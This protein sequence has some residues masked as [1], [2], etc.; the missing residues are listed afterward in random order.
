M[1]PVY[2]TIQIPQSNFTESNNS[3]K[4]C[5]TIVLTK[6]IPTINPLSFDFGIHF[7]KQQK[8][9]TSQHA[10]LMD[11]IITIT[12]EQITATISYAKVGCL[13]Q[14]LT[15]F[16]IN[17]P[18]QLSESKQATD[19]SKIAAFINVV[20]LFY[21]YFMLITVKETKTVKEF[22]QLQCLVSMQ[23]C[24]IQIVFSK[25]QYVNNQHIKNITV[26]FVSIYPLIFRQ[27]GCLH[28]LCS[29]TISLLVL[30][31][32]YFDVFEVL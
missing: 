14:R 26:T 10:K 11:A 1:A 8:L 25:Q 29:I 30:N 12:N 19:V 23:L 15:D 2:R 22:T 24:D 18:S 16:Y 17:I 7:I 32:I 27:L 5:P 4:L 9:P 31:D 20:S 28:N 13:F 3:Y 6:N 21:L